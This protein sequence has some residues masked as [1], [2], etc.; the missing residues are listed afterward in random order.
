MSTSDADVIEELLVTLESA[1]NF[2]RGT[3]FDQRIPLDTR[4]AM[5]E[6]AQEIDSIC[7]K[8]I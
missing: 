2:M 8:Y 5:A 7:E 3:M 4:Q 6:R 1:A